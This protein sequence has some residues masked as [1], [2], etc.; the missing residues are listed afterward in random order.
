MGYQA[1]CEDIRYIYVIYWTLTF[2]IIGG[3]M[4]NSNLS[5]G[6]G[7]AAGVLEELTLR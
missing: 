1:F 3:C 5:E 7:L 6:L 4:V 2:A